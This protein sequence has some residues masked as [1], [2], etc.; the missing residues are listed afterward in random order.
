[1]NLERERERRG[2]TILKDM[3]AEEERRLFPR[4]GGLTL[5]SPW[6]D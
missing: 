6:I 5:K 2:Q 3:K 4:H 1:M